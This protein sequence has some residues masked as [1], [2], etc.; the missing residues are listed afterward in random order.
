MSEQY[1][2][3]KV[4]TDVSKELCTTA[5]RAQSSRMFTIQL[6]ILRVYPSNKVV[7]SSPSF[8]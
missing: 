4:P 7:S 8:P 1:L 6:R 3:S 2:N 5:A